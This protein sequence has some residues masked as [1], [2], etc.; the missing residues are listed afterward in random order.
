[1][2]GTATTLFFLFGCHQCEHKVLMSWLISMLYC[3]EWEQAMRSQ[4]SPLTYKGSQI[5]TSTADVRF[6]WPFLKFDVLCYATRTKRV[7]KNVFPNTT[8]EKNS[9]Y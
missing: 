9:S 6:F 5:S 8:G 3:Q 1:M 2:G 7:K 4:F